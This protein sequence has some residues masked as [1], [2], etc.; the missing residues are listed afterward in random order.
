MRLNI[1]LSN[2]IEIMIN[3]HILYNGI[4]LGID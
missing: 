4:D 1:D 2:I 3:C